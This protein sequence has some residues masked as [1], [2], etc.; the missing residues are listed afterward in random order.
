[1]IIDCHVHIVTPVAGHG[2]LSRK[3]RMRPS[4]AFIRWR[5][6]ISFFADGAAFERQSE[7]RLI[8]S[9][10]GAPEIDAGVV[11]AFD[12]VHTNEGLRDPKR[13]NFAVTNDYVI[14]FVRQNQKLLFAASIH[15]Y[16]PDALAELDRC[17]AAGAVMIKWLPLVQDFNPADERCFPFYEALAHHRLPLLSH[18]GG[19]LSLPYANMAYEDPA[20]LE[21]ALRRGVTVIAAHCGTR[22]KPFEPDYLPTFVRMAKE[23]ERLYGDTAALNLPTRSYAYSTLLND[24]QIRDKLVHGSDWPIMPV[25]PLRIGA[26]RAY[27]LLMHE[28]NWIRR[29]VLIKRNLGFDEAYW[30]R[31]AT[32]LRLPK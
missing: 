5:Q 6:G 8:E 29:D 20:F 16:R 28:S 15:P 1:M 26:G 27:Q 25:P 12:Y 10:Q 4:S 13:T 3:M 18:T 24:P 2:V 7:A 23:H 17:I 30:H 9:V 21:P 11:L 19:E 14:D 31:G 32:L 22:A